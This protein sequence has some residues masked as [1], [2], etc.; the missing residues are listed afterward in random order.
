VA[1][2]RW[3]PLE[4]IGLANAVA[5]MA[6]FMGFG[7]MSFLAAFWVE[8]G[9]GVEEITWYV[10]GLCGVAVVLVVVFVRDRP[11]SAP[12]VLAQKITGRAALRDD[13]KAMLRDSTFMFATGIYGLVLGGIWTIPSTVALFLT[14]GQSDNLKVGILALVF[15]VSGAVASVIFESVAKRG[16]NPFRLLKIIY[17]FAILALTFYAF[18]VQFKVTLF[19]YPSLIL[20]GIT[21]AGSYP[22]SIESGIELTFPVQESNSAQMTIWISQ[23]TGILLSTLCTLDSTIDFGHWM[24]LGFIGIP[25]ASYIFFGRAR[26]RRLEFEE[27][28]ECLEEKKA[29][30]LHSGEDD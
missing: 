17:I 6:N 18:A 3:F 9:Y 15:V 2:E 4:E 19:E 25:L 10:L 27:K 23:I 16:V 20:T 8:K 24:L 7:S 26:F 14:K 1:A 11:P 21:F 13:M 22:L 30:L 12:N 5:L 29:S 28:E